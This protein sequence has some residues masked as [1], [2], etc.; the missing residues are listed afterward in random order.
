MGVI[1]GYT[2]VPSDVAQRCRTDAEYCEHVL[3]REGRLAESR[4][5]YLDKAWDGLSYLISPAR[6]E[7]YNSRE[8]TDALRQAI[9]GTE[10]LNDAIDAGYGPPMLVPPQ[11]VAQAAAL[12]SAITSTALA[13]HFDPAAMEAAEVYPGSWE[14]IGLSY[15]ECYFEDLRSFYAAAA[16]AAHAVLVVFC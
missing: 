15:P 10:P 14:E 4:H 6:R 11:V 5:L 13:E 8:S 3:S 1:A 2:S 9:E 7:A 16:E 12:L